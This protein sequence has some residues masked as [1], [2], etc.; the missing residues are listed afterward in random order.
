[1]NLNVKYTKC[2]STGKCPVDDAGCLGEDTKEI[3]EG[4]GDGTKGEE[5]IYP[6]HPGED[7]I[8][9]RTVP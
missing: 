5:F 2:P 7:N 9:T 6:I 8:C 1:V 4:H 3:Y